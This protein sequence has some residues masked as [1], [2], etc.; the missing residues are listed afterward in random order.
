[1][2]DFVLRRLRRAPIIRPLWDEFERVLAE[3]DALRAERDAAHS[4]AA[5]VDFERFVADCRKLLDA[6][7]AMRRQVEDSGFMV[8]PA[9][10]NSPAPLL[11]ELDHTFEGAAALYDKIFD[12]AKIR[13][14]LE[15]MAPFA[16]EF[17]P[18]QSG[19]EQTATEFFWGNTHFGFTDAVAYYGMIRQ[20]RPMR[21]V[22]IGSGSSTLVATPRSGRTA[23]ARSSAST[24]ISGLRSHASTPSPRPSSGRS[25]RCRL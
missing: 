5:N 23:W 18:P 9:D 16:S 6:G 21:I 1:M 14:A 22:E 17:D 4:N 11:R 7:P 19:D 3:R 10:F 15:A 25:K 20:R 24:R 8:L 2:H 12:P 13:A